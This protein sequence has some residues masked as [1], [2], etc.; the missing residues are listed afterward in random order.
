MQTREP[1]P[2]LPLELQKKRRKKSPH[3][4]NHLWTQIL[5]IKHIKK[6]VLELHDVIKEKTAEI[7]KSVYIMF[8][9][10]VHSIKPRHFLTPFCASHN[11]GRHSGWR[12]YCVWNV[13]K[14]TDTH[15]HA[16]LGL[17]PDKPYRILGRRRPAFCWKGSLHLWVSSLTK[18]NK[19]SNP[20][21][22]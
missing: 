15:I 5:L 4:I 9:L 2:H 21:P 1:F 19:K 13:D 14:S 20:P 17:G 8:N 16:V 11:I 6:K 22:P 10:R 3:Q 12:I 18:H 7:T